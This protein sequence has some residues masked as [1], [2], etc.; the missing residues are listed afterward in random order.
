M[1]VV[2]VVCVSVCVCVGGGGRGV[3]RAG[4]G[5]GEEQILR[6]IWQEC[7]KHNKTDA[8]VG[9]IHCPVE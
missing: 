6:Q 5:G 1:V 8:K 2:A 9:Q 4:D 7:R 3:L